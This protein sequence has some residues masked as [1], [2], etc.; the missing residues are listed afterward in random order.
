MKF[1]D[2]H[3]PTDRMQILSADNLFGPPP[4]KAISVWA[5]TGA[6]VAV[7]LGANLL[8]VALQPAGAAASQRR[9]VFALNLHSSRLP[10]QPSHVDGGGE[11]AESGDGSAA[12][13]F[14]AG[15]AKLPDSPRCVGSATAAVLTALP[16][17]GPI[18]TTDY[19]HPL[20]DGDAGSV[21]EAG[22]GAGAGA[23]LQSPECAAI[24]RALRSLD[25][26]SKVLLSPSQK[27]SIRASRQAD[28]SRQSA[29]GC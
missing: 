25:L 26:A 1:S 23:L 12:T 13:C 16:Q 2:T 15:S 28:R 4:P 24:E 11:Q 18:G 17:V 6:I 10:D 27:D 29:L 14:A 3:S 21:V 8:H 7:A 9:A 19:Q 5:L 20:S 22:L